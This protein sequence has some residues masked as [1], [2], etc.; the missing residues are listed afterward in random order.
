MSLTATTTGVELLPGDKL[1]AYSDAE[2]R[3]V[4]V[5]EHPDGVVYLSIGGDQKASL[6]FAVERDDDVIA[7]T[8][9][10][11]SFDANAIIGSQE[12]PER[13]DFTHRDSARFGW[14]TLDGI[15][16]DKR[17]VKRGVYIYNGKKYVIE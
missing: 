5:I 15:K 9:D 10:I 4:T 6:W 3:G 13:I 14:Y 12:A 11:M 2:L 7:T 1:L 16:L 17:P 8:T